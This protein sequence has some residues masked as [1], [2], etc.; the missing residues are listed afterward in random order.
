MSNINKGENIFESELKAEYE[1]HNKIISCLKDFENIIKKTTNLPIKIDE[2]NENE[3]VNMIYKKVKYIED[4]LLKE[5]PFELICLKLFRLLFL[6]H[7]NFN[8]D[9][10]DEKSKDFQLVLKLL[11]NQLDIK[12]KKEYIDKVMEKKKIDEWKKLLRLFYITSA[13]LELL[14]AISLKF[15]KSVVEISDFLLLILK[16]KHMNS[17]DVKFDLIIMKSTDNTPY[18]F[19]FQKYYLIQIIIIFKINIINSL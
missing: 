8:Y 3:I 13:D 15:S 1:K 14:I 18:L 17:F 16:K 12:E 10:L 19:I 5:K 4:E 6:P 9:N 2:F 7:G 11:K